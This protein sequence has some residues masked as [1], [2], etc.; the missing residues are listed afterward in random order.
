MSLS[1]HA[2][3]LYNSPSFPPSPAAWNDTSTTKGQVLLVH[4]LYYLCQMTLNRTNVPRLCGRHHVQIVSA[5]IE[6]KCAQAV[7]RH[8]RMQ[9]QLIADHLLQFSDVTTI[10]PIV[11]YAA[12]SAAVILALSSRSK[13][14][15]T[16]PST[17]SS[18]DETSMKSLIG[19]VDQLSGYWKPLQRLVGNCRS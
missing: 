7:L 13:E 15:G 19:L 11:G 14:L 17:L 5:H 12:F 16:A 1:S 6:R 8:A 4:S 3:T 2:A 9:G 18:D 10:S